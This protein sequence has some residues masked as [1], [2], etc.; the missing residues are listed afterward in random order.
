MHAGLDGGQKWNLL[1]QKEENPRTTTVYIKEC[2]LIKD[3]LFN[4][5]DL[6]HSFDLTDKSILNQ[7]QKTT[8]QTHLTCSPT[9]TL[10]TPDSRFDLHH[11]NTTLPLP[12]D[13]VAA[14]HATTDR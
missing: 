5:S 4:K 11:F 14:M 3:L 7:S 13:P 2:I 9:T 1:R 8:R 10:E 6:Q 12:P